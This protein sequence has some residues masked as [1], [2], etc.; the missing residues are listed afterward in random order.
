MKLKPTKRSFCCR[1]LSI[2]PANGK[3]LASLDSD[4]SA[5]DFKF[6]SDNACA[7]K[8]SLL[9]LVEAAA[10]GAAPKAVARKFVKAVSSF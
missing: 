7:S 8:K 4:L 5:R 9:Y 1:I 6:S 10:F 3:I 2:F